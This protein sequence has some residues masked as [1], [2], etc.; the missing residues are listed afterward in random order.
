[1]AWWNRSRRADSNKAANDSVVR[2]AGSS[3]RVAAIARQHLDDDVAHRWLGLTRP[4]IHFT[5]AGVGQDPFLRL[6]GRPLVPADFSWPVWEGHGPLSYIAGL[7]LRAVAGA[8]L[9]HGLLLPDTGWLHFFYFDGSYD[10]FDSIVGT[11]DPDSLAGARV[12]HV[13]G[14]AAP[15]AEM[16]PPEGVPEFGRRDLVGQQVVTFPDWEHPVLRAEFQSPGTDHREWMSHPVNS[17]SFSD[18]LWDLYPA[19][20]RHQL[21]GW[22]DPVQ[23]P[24]E[25]EVDDA[26]GGA[27]S[28]APDA[29]VDAA[30]RWNLLLQID[31]DDDAEMMWGDCGMLY[32]MAAAAGSGPINAECTSF[33][34][35]CG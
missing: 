6:G 34:W 31:S 7:D 22:A 32:W 15:L 30:L 16:A 4:A 9:D 29:D 8:G 10:N 2:E 17:E 13:P 1:M 18:A 14:D 24:V 25:L 28:D 21:G 27:P 26:A 23:G 5:T 11:W 12:L 33:T 19:G 35:Q 20:P 3:A